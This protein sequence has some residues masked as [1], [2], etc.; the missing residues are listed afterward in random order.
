MPRFELEYVT[1]TIEALEPK[2]EGAQYPVPI[3]QLPSSSVQKGKY[4][5]YGMKDLT[6]GSWMGLGRALG[7]G[8]REKLRQRFRKY[9]FMK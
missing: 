4:A 3:G 8:R 2:G 5:P 7:D 1:Y 6:I 9:M